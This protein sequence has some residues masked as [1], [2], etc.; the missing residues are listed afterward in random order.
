[1]KRFCITT[2]LCLAVSLPV[3]AWQNCPV[4]PLP[5]EAVKGNDTF[6][7][8]EKTPLV[9][10]SDVLRST[11]D[12][13]RSQVIKFAG[14][15]LSEAK[16]SDDT[17]AIRLELTE[18]KGD[19][20]AYELHIDSGGITIRASGVPGVFNGT[21]SVLQLIANTGKSGGQVKIPAW[22]IRDA[23]QY[24][25]RGL[26][27]DVSRYFI[28]KEKIVSLLDWMA[29]Y[30]LNRL[31]LHLTDE[32]G[33][34]IEIKKYPRLASV[35][36]VGD[37]NDPHKPAQY[38][39]QEDIAEIVEYAG[40][41]NITVIPEID[42]PGHA[43]AA[44][45]AYPQYS[46]GGSEQ[47]PEFTFD[48]ENEDT[49]AYLTGILKEVNGL[50]PSRMLHLGGDEVS[51]GNDKWIQSRGIK[52]LMSR[53]GLKDVRE[54]EYHFMKRMADSVYAMGAN[55]LAWDEL[56]DTDLPA[57]KTILFW[58]RHDKPEQLHKALE[59]GYRTVICPRLPYYFDFVQD[60]THNSGRKWGGKFSPIKDVYH[61]SAG[62]WTQGKATG[63]ILGVQANLWT[64]TVT[65][66]KRLDYLLFPR[67]AALSESAWT[68]DRD[69]LP[70]F[71]KRLED[72][73]E[74]YRSEKIYYY[75]P[76][77]PETTPEPVYTKKK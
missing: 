40:K 16:G 59:R 51:F 28:P 60:S 41:R 18:E 5:Q 46:G 6:L 9:V 55:L 50:F 32:P 63:K 22:Q 19:K 7:L 42:M 61:F 26:M 31:H 1:M 37:Q 44:N 48:P 77:K 36:G 76:L 56:A 12:Y 67:I 20:E 30:K 24:S 71:M 66:I 33:W 3:A 23:P 14:I 49:Y 58:W 27:L 4:I 29:F 17:P 34:R 64:E 10:A 38:F 73:L 54:V 75:N 62:D 45:R 57:D 68:T 21:V 72:H 53:H 74:L 35:G 13:F 43:T 2:I 15:S 8:S 52:E 25:W 65:S 39:T 47:H 69:D 11:A 70:F